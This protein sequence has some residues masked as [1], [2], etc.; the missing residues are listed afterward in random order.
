MVNDVRKARKS[1]IKRPRLP[2]FPCPVCG[3][4]AISNNV[5]AM[6]RLTRKF[7]YFCSNHGCGH[8]FTTFMEFSA[9]ISPSALG[10]VDK[11]APMLRL[12]HRPN[13]PP[14]G[15]PPAP[16]SGQESA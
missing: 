13:L 6:S 14:I 5:E 2:A 15:G 11:P 16:T 9:T 10:T 3:E 1:D 7:Y 8:T 4:T 12:K